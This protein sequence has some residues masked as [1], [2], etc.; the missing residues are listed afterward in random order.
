MADIDEAALTPEQTEDL[1]QQRE[2]LKQLPA[3]MGGTWEDEISKRQLAKNAARKWRQEV[4]DKEAK[5]IKSAV[6]LEKAIE[7]AIKPEELTLAKIAMGAPRKSVMV[8]P[9]VYGPNY[10]SGSVQFTPQ[11]SPPTP[12]E[13]ALMDRLTNTLLK[14]LPNGCRVEKIAN[15]VDLEK[16][17]VAVI[18]RAEQHAAENPSFI[19]PGV[20]P[21]DQLIADLIKAGNKVIVG[22]VNA[23]SLDWKTAVHRAAESLFAGIVPGDE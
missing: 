13:I 16:K 6:E 23:T 9:P 10:G 4:V 1:R 11:L 15:G 19:R 8:P 3:G 22:P 2:A 17:T 18:V 21:R 20:D 5:L 12:E 7:V 14:V